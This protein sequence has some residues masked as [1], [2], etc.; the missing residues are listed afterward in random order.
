MKLHSLALAIALVAIGCAST[1]D[2]TSTTAPTETVAN[3]A[4]LEPIEIPLTLYVVD[5]EQIPDSPL[6]TNR[7]E[8]ELQSIAVAMAAIWAQAGVVFEPLNVRR[9]AASED[10]IGQIATA[11]NSELF[12]EQAGVQ[13]D[14]PDLGTIN[15]FYLSEAA[16]VNGFTPRG[17][18]IFFVVDQPTV[19]DER[20]S[21]H[22]IGHILGLHH[23]LEDPGRLMFS[24]TNGTALTETE[25]QVARYT[26]QGILNNQR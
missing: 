19:D 9:V 1:S 15:G 12:F 4:T 26:A 11:G 23:V 2:P 10:A 7:T 5:I 25:Q 17:S 22:E 16:G 3:Q 13:F 18:R 24:G 21:S 8:E 6:A 20:V 14:V